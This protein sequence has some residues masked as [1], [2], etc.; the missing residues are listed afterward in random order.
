MANHFPD[1][2]S[3]PDLTTL[4]FK[5]CRA[6]GTL[7]V[8][9]VK[10]IPGG[11]LDGYYHRNEA[12]WGVVDGNLA[13]LTSEGR[14]STVFNRA[15]LIDGKLVLEGDFLLHPEMKIVHQLRQ[16]E[17]DFQSRKR[18]DRLT[19]HHLAA[20]IEHFGW[21]I[22]DHTYGI[23]AVVEKAYSK[24]RIGKFC[25]I[26]DGVVIVLANHRMDGVTT[27]PFASLKQYWPALNDCPFADHAVKGDVTIGND[28]WIGYGA[29]ILSG[30]TIGDGAVIAARSVVTKDVPPFAIYGGNP[31]KVLKYRH[32][33]EDIASLSRIKWW[34]WSDEV[35]NERLPLM[36]ADMNAFI[37]RYKLI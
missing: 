22:G 2:S 37:E 29:T 34:E 9:P 26:A 32:C 1:S 8:A 14:P 33:E 16:I 36:M 7:D 25:S 27:Y 31:G 3:A 10:L 23:P 28:V 13:F 6:D 15:S 5:L 19:A 30:V 20:E 18:H 21:V 35:I 11:T 24:L 12:A 17:W 4:T